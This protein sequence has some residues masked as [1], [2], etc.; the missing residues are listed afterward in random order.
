MCLV[1]PH[2]S[3][4]SVLEEVA[5]AMAVSAVRARASVTRARALPPSFSVGAGPIE[6][7]EAEDYALATSSTLVVFGICFNGGGLLA[8]PPFAGV[9]LCAAHTAQ[10]FVLGFRVSQQAWSFKDWPHANAKK[11][12]FPLSIVRLSRH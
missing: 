12:T 2:G 8:I 3:V 11:H 9:S 1:R 10:C 5:M 6:Q 7:K 4:E